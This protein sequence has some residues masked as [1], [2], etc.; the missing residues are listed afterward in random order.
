MA[1]KNP[2]ETKGTKIPRQKTSASVMHLFS[3]RMVHREV[4]GTLN[5]MTLYYRLFMHKGIHDHL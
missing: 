1:L 4:D 5:D 3:A 2:K